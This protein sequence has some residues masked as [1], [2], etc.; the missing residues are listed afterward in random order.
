MGNNYGAIVVGGGYFGCAC[1]YFL[2]KAGVSTLL[3]DQREIGRGASGANFGNVQ[4]QDASM[5]LSYE[6]TLA[7]FERMKTMERELDS[8][9]GYTPQPSLLAAER[10]GHLE[11]LRRLYEEKKAAGLDIRWLDEAQLL[12]VEP[13]MA[14]GA[15]LAATYFVQGRVYPFHYMYALVR[16]GRKHGLEVREKAGPVR[17]LTEGGRCTG[18]QL[19]N[20]AAL[21][22]EHV[23]VTAGSG[24]AELCAGAGLNVPVHSVKA[25][26]FVTEAIQPF[27]RSYYS[28]AAF[29]DEAH[30]QTQASTTLCVGQSHYGNILLAE[31]T[32]PHQSVDADKQDC[33]SLEHCRNLRRQLLRTYPALEKVQILR[34]WVTASPSTENNE[35]ILGKSPVPGLILAA[36]FKSAVVMSAVAGEIVRDLVTRDTCA[37]DIRPFMAPVT[38]LERS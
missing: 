25:E 8:D 29:F 2:A 27:L 37:W 21:R 9:I 10:P 14:P 18:V 11:G 13:N 26:A 20:G 31:T 35:P 15:V 4:V 6:L 32:K 34:S 3:M 5:G 1:A 16:Q 28:S 12:E 22:A 33:T 23:I 36:G 38:F 30:S 24:T 7:G 17:L 19:E